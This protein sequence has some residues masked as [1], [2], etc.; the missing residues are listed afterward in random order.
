[1]H[2][3]TTITRLSIMLLAVAF[4][5]GACGSTNANTE[6][7]SSTAQEEGADN[8]TGGNAPDGAQK[9]EGEAASDAPSETEDMPATRLYE[10]VSGETE[11]PTEPKRIV[12]DWYYGDMVA[13]GVKP[14]G[15]TSYVL[16]NHPFIEPDG[17]EDIG[18]TPNLEK[19]LEMEPDLIVLYGHNDS[20]E[21]FSKIAPTI[22]VELYPDPI[23]SV[24]VF[25]DILGKQEEAEQW[26]ADFE[27]KVE[28][29]QQKIAGHVAPDET[30]TIFT[31]W[32]DELR[33]YGDINM[34]GYILYKA[35]QLQPQERVLRD[36]IEGDAVN[37]GSP[38]SRE[39]LPSFAGD[40]I[41]LTVFDGEDTEQ[42]LKDSAIWKSLEAV[43]NDR[44]YEIDFDLLYNEDP[45]AM[46]QQID[47][48]TDAITGAR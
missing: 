24:Q 36:I 8:A 6:S 31:V 43:Q 20:Y 33:V 27:A 9:S 5:L 37:A 23:N 25:G 35:L 42:T 28:Q 11:I 26:I 19:V 45:V 15:L 2:I 14:I 48:L 41:I 7:A 3:A 21:E 18:S 34:G 22:G 47:I 1:M 16:N 44:V 38:I 39:A 17:T 4:I 40:H 29:A 10:H 46:E 32:R 30:F 12:S 13:L